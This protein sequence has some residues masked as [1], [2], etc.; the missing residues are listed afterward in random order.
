MFTTRARHVWLGMADRPIFWYRPND[1]TY[2]VVYADLSVREADAP[3]SMPAALPEPGRPQGDCTIAVKV[4]A[5]ATGNPVPDARVYLFYPPTSHAMF[6]NTDNDGT[7]IFENMSTGPYSLRTI[8][9]AGYQD[10]HYDPEDK[11]HPSAMFSLKEGE[12]RREIVLKL[13]QACR[14]SGKVVDENGTVPEDAGQLFVSA[15]FKADDREGYENKYA[16]VNGSNCSYVIDGL[17]DKPAYVMVENQ[18][19]AKE[20]DSLPPI[21]YPGTFSRSDARLVTFENGRSVENI[22]IM[23]RKEGG[24]RIAGT[25]R[26]EAG[27]P[28]PEAFVVVHPR[29]MCGGLATAYTDPE[30]HYQIQGLGEG[31]FLVHVDAV[32][33]GL[34]RTRMPIRLDKTTKKTELSFTLHQGATI[35]G[36]LVDENGRDWKVA[37]NLVGRA[38]V[39]ASDRDGFGLTNVDF[40][41]KYRPRNRDG[42]ARGWLYFGKGDYPDGELIFPT[43]SSFIIQGMMPGHTTFRLEYP[44]QKIAKVLHAGQDILDSGIDTEPGQEI[45]DITIVIAKQ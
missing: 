10:A 8:N 23:R 45:K 39:G 27:K 7:H 1:K 17:S 28:V 11:G 41:N 37:R 34:V 33:R 40:R 14:I 4:V 32:H 3:P 19:A 20:G 25:V 15:W 18:R 12:G 24:Q 35:S 36:K 42:M 22:N 16:V 9:T 2:R 38:I 29:D 6:V 43:N 13:K 5:E 44:P 30:G 31:E 21:Y 26:D